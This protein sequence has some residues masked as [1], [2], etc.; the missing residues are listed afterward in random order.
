MGVYTVESTEKI[1]EVRE[2]LTLWMADS[3]RVKLSPELRGGRRK[4]LQS[5]LS[6]D[7][8]F[9]GQ[10]SLYS[11]HNFHAF[12]AKFPPQIPK[13]FI[14]HL[15]APNELIADTMMGSGTTILEALLA[16]RRSVGFDLDPLA[17]LLCTI[18]TANIQ[19]ELAFQYGKRVIGGAVKSLEDPSV[20]R[21]QLESEFDLETRKFI[22]YWFMPDT[23]LQLYAISKA[24]RKTDVPE[25]RSFLELCFSAIIV[26]KSGGVSLAMDLA[27]SRP[28]KVAGKKPRNAIEEFEKRLRK[29]AASLE[30]IAGSD[31]IQLHRADTRR[32]PMEND[33]VD[34][35]VTSPPYANA[36][37]YVRAHKFS[38]VWF[39]IPIGQLSELRAE[40]IGSERAAATVV[41]GYGEISDEVLKKLS[42]LDLKKARILAKY[43]DD[44]RGAFSEMHRITKPDRCAVVVVGSSTMRGIDVRTPEC[45]AE[46]AR[47]VGWDV[48]GLAT[49]KI[50]RDKRM[51]PMRAKG[52][53]K[54]MIE[55]RMS[56]EAVIGLYKNGRKN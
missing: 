48:V 34:L 44:M 51:M 13:F 9:R 35:I 21:K 11:R 30:H 52:T 39:G 22:D 36:I 1:S 40:Y 24:I 7:L 47:K 27:H 43:F 2:Q 45:L 37:D 8:D 54:S 4:I 25:I 17:V 19:Q 50:D 6:Q 32:L 23:Q 28:H 14:E 33:S 41:A 49:R 16:G 42:T 15:S 53:P 18:K 20:L 5:I 10:N 46:V 26:T 56:E 29:N 31:R 38:L 12:A 3:S 55:E